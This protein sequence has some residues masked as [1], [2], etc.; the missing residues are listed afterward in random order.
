MYEKQGIWIERDSRRAGMQPQAR[1]CLS[2]SLF[3]RTMT[4]GPGITPGLLTLQGYLQALAGYAQC[5][6]L[7]PVG[8][9]TPP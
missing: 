3:I 8:N 1:R 7:P 5:A 9:C 6:Q 4:V 2:R